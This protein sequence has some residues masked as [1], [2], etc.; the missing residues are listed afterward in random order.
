[1]S[2]SDF[3][4]SKES[5][6]QLTQEIEKLKAYL[7][8]FQSGERLSLESQYSQQYELPLAFEQMV[9]AFALSTFEKTLIVLCAAWE[10]DQDVPELCMRIRG[11]ETPLNYPTFGLALQILPDAGIRCLDP[12]SPLIRWQLIE[13]ESGPLLSSFLTLNRWVLYYLLGHDY[14]DPRFA[15][16]LQPKWVN[17]DQSFVPKTYDAIAEQLWNQWADSQTPPVTQL[18]G[19]DRFA[20]QMIAELV[21]E[22]YGCLLF[23]VRGNALNIESHLVQDWMMYWQRQAYL[24]GYALLIECDDPN[25]L[26]TQTQQLIHELIET[27]RTPLFLGSTDRFANLR[28]ILTIDIPSLNPQEQKDLW[29]YHLGAMGPQL[30][31]QIGVLVSQFNLNVSAIQ[32]ISS[33]AIAQLNAYQKETTLDSQTITRTLWSMCCTQSRSRLEGL[34][35]RQ[36]PKTTWDDLILPDDSI[37]VLQQIIS[38]IRQR[39]KV[40]DQWGMGG[41]TRRGMGITTLFYGPPGTGKTTAAEIIAKELT[42]DLYRVDLSQ[43]TSKYIGE[44]EKNLA[45]IF[46]AGETSGAVLLFD[47]ADSIIGKRTDV[48]DSKDRYANQEVGY[49]LQR[50]EAYSGLAILTTNLPNAIDSAFMRRIRFSVRFEY[51]SAQQ[52]ALIWQK[53]FP[54]TVPTENLEWQRLAQLNV[55]GASIRNIAMGAAFLAADENK[56]IQMRHILRSAYAESMK[57]GRP[58]T[59]Q[60]VRGWV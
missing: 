53:N 11:E 21:C 13:M 52:R 12:N 51:P 32:S 40:F 4:W 27:T 6:A 14:T 17:I 1:M 15:S 34:V 25:Q 29:H 50:M 37:L 28:Q 24:K 49:L 5:C 48:K 3:D 9:D 23:S 35:Q 18:C 36:E 38:T 26:P 55:S 22:K 10:L 47:E 7:V 54:P 16:S 57:Q 20:Q 19:N 41:N 31:G 59:D 39:S 58:L 2:S 44:T 33:Q 30:N 60:E 42:L 43:V 46:D 56:P 8:L 45:Q